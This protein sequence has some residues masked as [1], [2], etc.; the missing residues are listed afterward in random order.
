M[1]RYFRPLEVRD[2]SYI[3]VITATSNVGDCRACESGHFR[4]IWK[5]EADDRREWRD[6]PN[7]IV[8]IPG[9]WSGLGDSD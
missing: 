9:D 8:K 1:Q 7:K 6:R 2:M 3:K 4:R 5:T